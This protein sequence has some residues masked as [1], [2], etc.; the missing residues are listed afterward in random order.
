M[1]PLQL[2]P[3]T[4]V[5][6]RPIEAADRA[7]LAAAFERLGEDSRMRRFLGPKHELS[8]REL[9]YLTEVDHVTHE[10]L[11]ALD[12]EENIVAV[13]RY[14][15]WPRESRESAE[16]AIVV[17]D[18][19]QGRGIGTALTAQIIARAGENGYARLGATTFGDNL[20][21]RRLLGRLGFTPVSTADGLLS[22][23]LGLPAHSRHAAEREPTR[24]LFRLGAIATEMA[25]RR[26]WRNSQPGRPV[27]AY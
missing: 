26:P 5:Q 14:A 18:A 4:T 16:V 1:T 25:I 11:V 10:A 19:W 9:T 7:A 20:A 21:S 22:F 27:P 3:H 13:A 24:R 12:D 15:A 8:T 23:E 6:V 2:D 17:L